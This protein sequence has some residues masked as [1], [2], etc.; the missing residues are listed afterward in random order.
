MPAS[1]YATKVLQLLDKRC[2]D[3]EPY[4]RIACPEKE[5]LQSKAIFRRQAIPTCRNVSRNGIDGNF[6]I[7]TQGTEKR[8]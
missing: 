1:S 3:D 5:G 8:R 4:D 7:D 2:T 6:K